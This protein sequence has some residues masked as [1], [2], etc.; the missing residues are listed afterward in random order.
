MPEPTPTGEHRAWE[1]PTRVE[2]V[3]ATL[4]VALWLLTILGLLDH[5]PWEGPLPWVASILATLL[6]FTVSGRLHPTAPTGVRLVRG[7]LAIA[8]TLLLAWIGF[9]IYMTVALFD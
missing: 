9:A 4:M 7:A 2:V 5:I 3:L 8:L 6:T 1:K